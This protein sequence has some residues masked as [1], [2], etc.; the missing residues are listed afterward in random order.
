MLK[1]KSVTPAESIKN[2]SFGTW[3]LAFVSTVKAARAESALPSYMLT[4]GVITTDLGSSSNN[5]YKTKGK[6]EETSEV[7]PEHQTILSTV[8]LNWTDPEVD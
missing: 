4:S 3:V 8:V 7:E 2:R 6:T 5:K 1:L